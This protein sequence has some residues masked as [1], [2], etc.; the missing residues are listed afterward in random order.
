MKP[1]SYFRVGL[2]VVG[3]LGLLVA[4]LLAFGAGHFLRPKLFFET[5][6]TTSIQGI[7]IGSPVKFRGLTIG[8]VSDLEFTSNIYH[9]QK[10]GEN[11]Y[12]R[13]VM[14]IDRPIFPGMFKSNT[15]RINKNIEQGLR[16]RPEPLGITG[17]SYL[18]LDYVN[19]PNR[20]P[21]PVVNWKPK[22]TYIPSVPGQMTGLLDSINKIMRDLETA[23]LS[24]IGKNL[25]DLLKNVN[26]A[27]EELEVKKLSENISHLTVELKQATND[28]QIGILSEKA[29]SFL[30]QSTSLVKNLEKTNQS[31][32]QILKEMPP[33]EIKETVAH[34]RMTSQ[35][36]EQISQ[37][38]RSRPSLLLYGTPPSI[39]KKRQ[40]T[41][42]HLLFSR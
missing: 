7:D 2:F 42:P 30:S 33:E 3:A 9:P 18:N 24:G 5:Y 41:R 26:K 34:V 15:H 22:Y 4:G 27:I 38:L 39:Q 36:L 8:K 17:S 35:N 23:N 25:T 13:V 6:L 14:E 21:A 20:S 1:S 16:V 32:D 10:G 28:A 29:A 31:L 19:T 40:Q 11:N 37:D 12:I